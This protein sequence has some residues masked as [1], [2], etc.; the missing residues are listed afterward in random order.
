MCINPTHT[1]MQKEI[2]TESVPKDK[3]SQGSPP[4]P[5]NKTRDLGDKAE[6]GTGPKTKREMKEEGGRELND[7]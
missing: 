6:L 7:N 4:Q 3:A 5:E 1:L 2:C